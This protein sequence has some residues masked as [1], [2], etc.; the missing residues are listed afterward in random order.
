MV[1]GVETPA[2]ATPTITVAE[3]DRAIDAL[4]SATG[5]GSV[6]GR[7]ELLSSLLGRATEP[8]AAFLRRLFTGELR[9]GALAGLMAD[10]V[11]QAAALP[12]QGGR[13][14]R[15]VS[16]ELSPTHPAGAGGGGGGPP[17]GGG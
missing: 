5:A 8:E 12:A 10:A 1:H 9:Q 7:R 6:T 3:V 15:V 16:P 4:E 17:A 2:A 13:R 11:A 14:G